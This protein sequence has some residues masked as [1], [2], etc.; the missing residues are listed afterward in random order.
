M[1]KFLTILHV[2][3]ISYI[4]ENTNYVYQTWK[5][6]KKDHLEK[7]V[8]FIDKVEDNKTIINYSLTGYCNFM[9]MVC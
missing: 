5:I 6:M 2:K 4:A 8:I 7:V 9:W 1:Y 3:W